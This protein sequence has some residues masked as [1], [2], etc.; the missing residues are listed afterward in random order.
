M[1]NRIVTAEEAVALIGDGDTIATS[2]FVGIGVP[3]ALLIALEQRFV[4]TGSPRDLTLVFAAGQ[5]DGKERGLNHLGHDGLLRRVIGGHW[6]LIP[7]VGRLALEGRIEAWNLPQG[8]ISHLYRDIAA[9]RPGVIS[10]VGLGTFVDPRVEGGRVNAISREAMVTL[11]RLGDT[12]YLFYKAFPIHVALIRATSADE[13]GNLSMEREALTL[14]SFAMA[15]AARNSGGLV[16]AQ[17]ERVVAAGSLDPR[18]VIVPATLVDV[19]VVAPAEHHGQTFATAYSPYFSGEVR[20]PRA[21]GTPLALDARKVIARRCALELPINGVVNLGIGMPEGVAAVADEERVLEHVTLTAEPGVI[22]G[23]PAGGL[24]FGAAVN[25]DAVVAQNQQFDFYDGGGLDLAVLGMA[26]VDAE[27]NVNVSRFGAKLAGAGGFINISQNARTVVFAGTFTAGGLK[28]AIGAGTLAITS[29]GRAPKFV[30]RVGQIT[31]SAKQALASGQTVL[32]V[33]ER[34]VFRLTRAGVELVE[35]APGIDLER[36][37][38]AHMAFTPVVGTPARMDAALF[39]EG[40]IGLA[41]RLFDLRLEDRFALD[42][43]RGQ[44]YINFDGLRVRTCADVDAIRE[45]VE[46][47]LAEHQAR[48]DV[49]VNY[50]RFDIDPEVEA[51]YAAMVH[52]LER[53]RYRHVSRY[54]TGAFLKL[55]MGRLLCEPHVPPIFETHAQAQAFLEQVAG[56]AAA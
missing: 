38:L 34:A 18:Q 45:R 24:D 43:A 1:R 26:E 41:E 35:V 28:L 56:P 49:I 46:Q 16:I 15:S 52:D 29:E 33:T 7:K 30:E 51:D 8:V 2:G 55:K 40:P 19:V 53:R 21:A 37:V 50:D 13:R 4:D 23:R 3:E 9:G 10:K 25:T 22:G 5:G 6:G 47:V 54:T 17:V 39:A 32:Y 12:D 48:V 11:T 36:D 20:A 27:G 14:D 31:F 44:L 42:A